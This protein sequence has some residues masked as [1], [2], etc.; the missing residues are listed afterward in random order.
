[1]DIEKAQREL[2]LEFSNEFKLY[3]KAFGIAIFEGHELTGLCDGKRLDVV[4]NTKEQREF[5]GFV[6]SDYYVIETPN[7]DGVVIWQ[8]KSGKVF[9]TM[10]NGKI[11]LLSKSLYEYLDTKI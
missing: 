7:I 11:E 8:N 4:N 10:P 2:N 5:N 9:Q 1:M 6:P 3:L